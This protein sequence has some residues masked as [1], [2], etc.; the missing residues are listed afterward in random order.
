[1]SRFDDTIGVRRDEVGSLVD[2]LSTRLTTLEGTVGAIGT[3]GTDLPFVDTTFAPVY[4]RTNKRHIYVTLRF[5]IP[6]STFKLHVVIVERALGIISSSSYRQNRHKVTLANAIEDEERD[7]QSVTDRVDIGLK[8][9][10]Q[11]DIIRLI[12]EDEDGGRVSNPENTNYAP[13]LTEPVG[14]PGN[15][16]YS[17]TTPDQFGVPSSPRLLDIL[18]NNLDSFTEDFDVKVRVRIYAP[19]T[20]AGA[21]QSWGAALVDKVAP[22]F[23]R[24]STGDKIK[25][26]YRLSG[27]ELT[28]VSATSPGIAN[29]GFVDIDITG[30]KPGAD[31]TWDKNICWTMGEKR[32]STGAAVAFVAGPFVRDPT[33]LAAGITLTIT[34]DDSRRASVAVNFTQPNPAVALKWIKVER[35]LTADP[36]IDAS[37]GTVV[38][39]FSLRGDEYYTVGAH[40]LVMLD[41]TVKTKPSKQYT[42]KA[43]VMALGGL[44]AVAPLLNT[45]GSETLDIPAA[46][47][48][49]THKNLIDGG[50]FLVNANSYG[51]GSADQVGKHFFIA[52]S[53]ASTRIDRTTTFAANGIGWDDANHRIKTGPT[54]VALG[55][56]LCC[57]IRKQILPGSTYNFNCLL[58]SSAPSLIAHSFTVDLWDEGAGAVIGGATLNQSIFVK[59]GNYRI[60]WG[61]FQVASTYQMNGRQWFRLYQTLDHS[62]E[63]YIDNL[64]LNKGSQLKLWEPGDGEAGIDSDVTVVVDTGSELPGSIATG[65]YDATGT[66]F[67]VAQNPSGT[68]VLSTAL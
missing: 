3:P 39:K 32:E 31:Y 14:Y 35:R 59:S 68:V 43:T 49:T 62:G 50:A 66:F 52:A 61:V 2:D 57:R 11:Y 13:T 41:D 23:S 26:E 17:F 40:P 63:L 21:A 16:L 67:Q 5:G 25:E 44:T 6:G 34:Q 20:D 54:I 58:K 51:T 64:C 10:T 56:K 15:V 18:F 38:K 24:T 28:Q 1:M 12:A 48:Q 29:R 9:N 33:T 37:Y 19:T 4:D 8:F 30:F 7:A 42:W 45:L 60:F 46:S 65:F 53:T 27:V 47:L 36:D 55:N 22:V